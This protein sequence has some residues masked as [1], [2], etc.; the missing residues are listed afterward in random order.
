MPKAKYSQRTLTPEYTDEEYEAAVRSGNTE[1]I[2]RMLKAKAAETQADIIEYPDVNTYSVRRGEMPKETIKV[3]KVFT[4][5]DQGRP[6]ALFNK[7]QASIRYR[8]VE[9]RGNRTVI[10]LNCVFSLLI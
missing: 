7:L 4:V 6:S 2:T 10:L 1:L 5:D 8:T 9:E 3:Y